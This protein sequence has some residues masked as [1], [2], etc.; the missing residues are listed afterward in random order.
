M[1]KK[2]ALLFVAL[3]LT[4]SAPAWA[5]THSEAYKDNIYTTGELKPVDSVLKVK[6][7]DM[8][9][10]LHASLHHGPESHPEPVP[11]Q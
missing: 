4:L 9:A 3:M 6:V 7:G 2:T 11:G 10:G 8:R 1:T 5:Q